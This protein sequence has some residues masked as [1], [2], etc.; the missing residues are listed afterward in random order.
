MQSLDQVTTSPLSVNSD[1]S[2]DTTFDGD[3]KLTTDISGGGSGDLGWSMAIQSD[4]KIVV[5]GEALDDGLNN[6]WV[7]FLYDVSQMSYIQNSG[8]HLI[9]GSV[10]I[11]DS[12]HA[13]IVWLLFR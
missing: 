2:L 12:D 5:A 3:G 13:N 11:S 10:T 9:N 8:M 6:D 7:V 1:G 4:G